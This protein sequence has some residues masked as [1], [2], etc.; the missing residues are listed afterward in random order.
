MNKAFFL[1]VPTGFTTLLVLVLAVL[2]LTVMV[3]VLAVLVLVLVAVLVASYSDAFRIDLA[4]INFHGHRTQRLSCVRLLLTSNQLGLL[5][6][7]VKLSC[8]CYL[9]LLVDFIILQLLV[10]VY[11]S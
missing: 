10:C 9:T 1:I 4:S 7:I 8:H 5:C 6:S 3:L 2:V 11:G